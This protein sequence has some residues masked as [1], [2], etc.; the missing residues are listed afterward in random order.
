MYY[1]LG[2]GVS[3]RVSDHQGDANTFARVGHPNDNYGIVIKLSRSRFKERDGVLIDQK[4][5]WK[6]RNYNSYT[7]AAPVAI[8]GEGYVGVAIAIVT[9]GHGT[10][11]NKFYLYKVVLQKNL[12]DESIKTDTEADSHRGDVAKILK[13]IVSAKENVE[14]NGN[15]ARLSLED[16][17]KVSDREVALRDAL[18]DKMRN[19]GMDVSTDWKE[20]QRVLDMA[21]GAGAT[22]SKAQ[23]K[24]LDTATMASEIAQ[25]NK[26]TAVS[27]TSGAK[28]L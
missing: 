4:E 15:D 22:L 17:G 18:V 26:A 12:L 28:V 5:N 14:K 2:G 13:E 10:N 1:D 3:L 9:R 27:S 8:G 16:E 21:N 19:A 11:T 25:A 23:K 20:G 24:I 6:K 7:I